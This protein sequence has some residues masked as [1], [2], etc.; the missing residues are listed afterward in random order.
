VPHRLCHWRLTVSTPDTTSV[1]TDE[2]PVPN[3]VYI[4][5]FE[6]DQ[7]ILSNI[8]SSMSPD[9]LGQCLFLKT[10]KEVWDKLD[11]L[12]VAQSWASAMQICM[13][14]ET[15]KKHNLST[16]DYFNRVKTLT[17]TLATPGASLRDDDIIAYL[18][19]GL[20]E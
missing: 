14:L 6:Q 11:G 4:Q 20:P 8:L 15:L 5:W 16:M 3:L 13:Q 2:A 9:I 12:Y 1:E 19:T 10:S 7:A 17:D 18:L